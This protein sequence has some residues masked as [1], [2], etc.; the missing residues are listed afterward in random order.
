[1]SF[2]KEMLQ[3][4]SDLESLGFLDV[5]IPHNTERYASNELAETSHEAVKE[6]LDRDLI[7]SYYQEIASAD[8]VIIANYDKNGIKNYIGGNSFLEAAFAHVLNKK[9]YFLFDIPEMMYSDE[10]KVFQPIVLNGELKQIVH[11]I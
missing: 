4:K 6:K 3:L 10:L 11:L 8:A 1:M 7:R 9:L 2:S 5:V